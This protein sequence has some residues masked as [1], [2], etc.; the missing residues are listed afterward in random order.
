MKIMLRIFL[1]CSSF[2]CLIGTA[3]AQTYCDSNGRSVS[4][5]YIKSVVVGDL[6]NL[7]SDARGYSDFTGIS[8]ELDKNDLINV[9]LTPGFP[10]SSYAENWV[11]YIDAN[12][13]GNFDEAT[14]RVFEGSSSRTAPL[15]GEFYV[16]AD[17]LQGS[18]RMRVIMNYS[19]VS[20]ACGSFTYGEVEDYT[21]TITGEADPD[22]PVLYCNASASYAQYFTIAGVSVGEFMSGTDAVVGYEDLT[23]EVIGSS[24]VLV[25]GGLAEMQLVPSNFTFPLRWTVWVDFNGDGIFDNDSERVFANTEGVNEP[26]T[27]SFEVPADIDIEETRFRIRMNYGPNNYSEKPCG[28]NYYGQVEDYTATFPQGP[29]QCSQTDCNFNGIED[30][31]E[32]ADGILQDVDADGTPDICQEDCNHN[33]YPDSYE[34]SPAGTVIPE[35]ERGTDV[36]DNGVPDSCQEDCNNNGHPDSYELSPAGTVI[37]EWERGTD[38]D[39]NGVPDSCQE[40]CNHNG[41]PD[42]FELSP[43]GTVISEWERGTD[44]DDDGT[45][46][47]CQEDCNNN[48]YPDS[49][50]LSPAGAVISEWERGTDMDD[51][52]TP[53]SCQED[54]NNNG[55]PDSYELSPAGAVIS[56]WERGTDMDDDGTPDSCQEDCN[57]NE[58]PDSFEIQNGMVDDFDQNGIPDQ[59]ESGQ[60]DFDCNFNGVD[61][62][63]EIEGEQHC[64]FDYAT[65]EDVCESWLDEDN[66]GQLDVCQ[67]DCNSNR[68]ADAKE[69]QDEQ[70][71]YFDYATNEDVCES[72]LDE[73]NNG[74]L[75][76]CQEDCNNNGIADTQDMSQD[77]ALDSDED[78]VIDICM[79]CA[80][81]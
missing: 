81:S 6:S 33:S 66:N 40:D 53:D 58:T 26:V 49:Y 23:R 64:Y 4:Y 24:I 48:G 17:A 37:S 42:S 25:P 38:L 34:L 65:N 29:E 21:V 35:W 31:E 75:D 9:T 63:M 56:E 55:Y 19:Q 30:A 10:G 80:V 60:S 69:I 57:N 18:T 5:E 41:Y 78:G 46:D 43:A 8:A 45:P 2:L 61:D 14:E 76:V 11:I 79:I 62:Q 12:Q 22:R 74:V 68:I 20:S 36:D 72:W 13:D 7:D 1:F 32:I 77:P 70:T 15:T 39:D 51:D 3:S 59:C 52:G 50:E 54:C 67:E 44:M 73:D 16:P 71:C 28:S 27:T 47:S